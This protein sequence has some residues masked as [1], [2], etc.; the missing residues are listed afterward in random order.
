MAGIS[1]LRAGTS[2]ASTAATGS[3][4]KGFGS[5]AAVQVNAA[6]QAQE[7]ASKTSLASMLDDNMYSLATNSGVGASSVMLFTDNW[8]TSSGTSGTMLDYYV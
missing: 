5:L 2:H 1:T 3:R 6:K 4:I 7:N 8:A